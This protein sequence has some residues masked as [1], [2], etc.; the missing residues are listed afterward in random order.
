MIKSPYCSYASREGVHVV[1]SG[2]VS[3]WPGI[4]AVESAHDAF[5]N[6][7][8][9]AEANDASWLLDF[10]NTFTNTDV[11]QVYYTYLLSDQFIEVYVHCVRAV[12]QIL[13]KNIQ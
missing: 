4:D 3:K 11:S 10:Y 6:G 1:F 9:P 7:T 2:E 5:M 13:R 8:A 12:K